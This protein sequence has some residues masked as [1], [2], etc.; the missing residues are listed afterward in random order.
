[1]QNKRNIQPRL[2]KCKDLP[3][4][5]YYVQA[6]QSEYAQ[7]AFDEERCL[8]FKGQWRQE[9]F[10]VSEDAPLDLEIGTGNGFHFANFAKSHPERQLIGLELKFKPLIQSIRRAVNEDCQNMRMVRYDAAFLDHL[11]AEQELDNVMIHFPD[12]WPKD[13][14]KKNRLVQDHFMDLIYDLQRSNRQ[15][16][17]KTD[18]RDYFDHAV[19]VFKNSKYEVTD[20]TYDLHNSEFAAGNFVTGFESIFLRKGQP[21]HLIR[22]IKP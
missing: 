18:N 21:I 9:V 6:L 7:W 3:V 4:P 12:P 15:I 5:T 1:M 14:Q 11:F 19:E 20:L 13:R 16:E 17:F 10:K 2:K 8:N 22:M